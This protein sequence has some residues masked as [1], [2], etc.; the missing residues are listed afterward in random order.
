MCHAV[1]VFQEYHG[2]T[3]VVALCFTVLEMYL[4]CNYPKRIGNIM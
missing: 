2:T 3:I 4:Q 1:R